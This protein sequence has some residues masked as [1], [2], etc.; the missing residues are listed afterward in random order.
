[1]ISRFIFRIPSSIGHP[2]DWSWFASWNSLVVNTRK[3]LANTFVKK[4]DIF[5]VIWKSIT[6]SFMSRELSNIKYFWSHTISFTISKQFP[7]FQMWIEASES[8]KREFFFRRGY[9][10]FYASLFPSYYQFSLLNTVNW[11]LLK[12]GA[13]NIPIE[14]PMALRGITSF[15]VAILNLETRIK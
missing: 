14:R 6:A 5:V 4:L 12:R 15:V 3:K 13:R 11:F 2:L 1:M 10:I 8:F 7:C 9:N